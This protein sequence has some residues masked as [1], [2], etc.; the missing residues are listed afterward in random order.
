MLACRNIIS[1]LPTAS[2]Q[3]LRCTSVGAAALV[4]HAVSKGLRD[5]THCELGTLFTQRLSYSQARDGGFN[6][7]KQVKGYLADI[8]KVEKGSSL[9]RMHY[10]ENCE[11]QVNH[12]INAEFSLSYAY[13]AMATY[14]ARDT[15][16]LKGFSQHF[17]AAS[18]EERKH[19]QQ[20]MEFQSMRGGK[21]KL[22]TIL[23][24][25]TEFGNT[26]KSAALHALEI[27]LAFEKMNYDNLLSLRKAAESDGDVVLV[28]LV[29]DM[30]RHQ[31]NDVKKAADLVSNLRLL[32]HSGSGILHFDHKLGKAYAAA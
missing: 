13:L 20:L 2:W 21:V 14:F 24:P 3:L 22:E 17:Y 7:Y 23:E 29:E 30:L 28:G 8:A 32:G 6:A 5:D 9:G 26:E 16:G 31:A 19:G 10:S 18:E 27:S 12:Q 4:Q 25:E 11:A 1:S 15:V